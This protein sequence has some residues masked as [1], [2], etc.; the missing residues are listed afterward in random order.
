MESGHFYGIGFPKGSALVAPTNAELAKIKTD[1][2]YK[3]IYRKWFG[4][5]PDSIPGV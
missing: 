1:G 4:K 2:R 3:A 5:D